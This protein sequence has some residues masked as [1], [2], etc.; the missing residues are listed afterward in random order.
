MYM[1]SFLL[2]SISMKTVSTMTT[3]IT[4]LLVSTTLM[5]APLSASAQV[6]A[7]P[8]TAPV[9][10]PPV[11]PIAVNQVPLMPAPTPNTY[12]TSYTSGGYQTQIQPAAIVYT[13]TWANVV[14]TVSGGTPVATISST[15]GVV[16]QKASPADTYSTNLIS[17]SYT[18]LSENCKM[19]CDT[20]PSGDGACTSGSLLTP[21]PLF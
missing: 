6:S 5:M 4:S 1:V 2:R 3:I 17:L 13:L 18:A 12:S 7:D 19:A 14:C 10:P 8:G 20:I 9:N 15:H 16:L 21:N 11:V